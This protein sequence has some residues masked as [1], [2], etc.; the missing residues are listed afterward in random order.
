ME[1]QAEMI[2]NLSTF[3][4]AEEFFVYVITVVRGVS[5]NQ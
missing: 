2:S 5:I 3:G 4:K 1:L